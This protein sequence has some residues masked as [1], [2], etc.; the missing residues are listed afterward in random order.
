LCQR[1]EEKEGKILWD[2]LKKGGRLLNLIN[3]GHMLKL[4]ELNTEI[5]S[6]FQ[7]H[8]R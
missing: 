4:E 8:E 2:Y 6:V 1:K 3:M 5:P 7:Q